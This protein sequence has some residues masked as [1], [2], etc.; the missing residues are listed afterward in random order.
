MKT[1]TFLALGTSTSGGDL[2]PPPTR[3]QLTDYRTHFQ[4]LYYETQ[5]YGRIPSG[6]LDLLSEWDRQIAFATHHA[7]IG[8]GFPNGD[9]HLLINISG[10]YKESTQVW[11]WALAQGHDW[12][13]DL[14]GFKAMVRSFITAGFFVD[15]RL[16]GDGLSVN[17]NP[18]FGEYNDPVGSTYGFQWLMANFPRIALALA[19]DSA[20][21]CPDGEDL[22]PY[23]VFCPGY[24]GVFY[25]WSRAGETPDPQPG[26]VAA[27]GQLFRALLPNGVLAIEHGMG[28]IP[29]GG[30]A[31]DYA[32]SGR[33]S[34][35]DII[36]GE[37]P[38]GLERSHDPN[39]DTNPGCQTWMVLDR[40]VRP[41]NRPSD[42]P[43]SP[44]ER[45]DLHPPYYLANESPRGPYV[46]VAFEFTKFLETHGSGYPVEQTEACREYLI[47]M[48]CNNVG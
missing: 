27:F 21:A 24:D 37:F 10:S 36:M 8:P 31:G 16:A 33:M 23:C 42:M 13:N 18:S 30:G 26:R 4:G 17:D 28:T 14:R 5:Q 48:G 11:P 39:P 32:P 25:G 44:P 20:S 29:V 6:W 40:M 12:T 34:T 43:S 9:T 15:I 46:Y 22:T 3:A 45:W 41:W 2:P 19:G 47:G 35:Y 7:A 1:A 38:N